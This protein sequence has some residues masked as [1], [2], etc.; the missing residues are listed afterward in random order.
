MIIEGLK[1][2]LLGMLGVF[3]FLTLLILMVKL[4]ASLL[5]NYSA[6]ESIEMKSRRGRTTSNLL[7]ENSKLV[8]I[9]SAALAAHIARY[10][11][12]T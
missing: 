11:N 5:K 6:R 9:I 4:S 10:Q 8:G 12:R 3:L 1:L 2:T 7:A